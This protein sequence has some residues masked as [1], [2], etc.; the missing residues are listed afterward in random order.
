MLKLKL[1]IVSL[2]LLCTQIHAGAEAGISLLRF[3]PTD[4]FK[5]YIDRGFGLDIYG[6]WQPNDSIFG[7]GNLV[8]FEF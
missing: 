4:N 5:N 7:T 6:A 8:L 3:A 1:F 2:I